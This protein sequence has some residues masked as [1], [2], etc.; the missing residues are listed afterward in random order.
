MKKVIKIKESDIKNIVKRII[1]EQLLDDESID[2][3][4]M[5]NDEKDRFQSDDYESPQTIGKSFFKIVIIGEK[6]I[7][8]PK[9]NPFDPKNIR[10]SLVFNSKERRNVDIKKYIDIFENKF[11]MRSAEI[12]ITIL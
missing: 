8:D 4:M 10:P 3:E 7:Q 11:G 2:N 6:E 9:S 12:K 5:K 1:N